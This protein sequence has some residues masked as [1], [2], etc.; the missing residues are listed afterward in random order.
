VSSTAARAPFGP[1]DPGFLEDIEL[2]KRLHFDWPPIAAALGFDW[3]QLPS[4]MEYYEILSL[5]AVLRGLRP[6]VSIEIGTRAGGSLAIFSRFS[7]QAISIDINPTS[8]AYLQNTLAN[9]EFCVGDSRVLL[10]DLLRRLEPTQAGPTF[11]FLDGDHTAEGVCADITNALTFKPRYPTV[12]MGH[13]SFNPDCRKG[14]LDVR[15][16]ASPHVHVVELDFQHGSI[17]DRTTP[18]YQMW[19]GLFF[20]LLLPERR[21]GSLSVS[22]RHQ[23][24]FDVAYARSAHRT[25]VLSRCLDAVR[26]L[27]P[28]AR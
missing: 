2:A 13:D 17:F 18:P 9:V 19:G 23:T 7:G 16:D 1:I 14:M 6:A 26:K 8:R 25:S 5:V 11:I 4:K 12:V 27:R 28:T 15:W 10:P 3:P 24:L 22:R 20:A 21:T